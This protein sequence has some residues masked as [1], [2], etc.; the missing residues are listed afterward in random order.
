[1]VTLHAS[2][3]NGVSSTLAVREIKKMLAERFHIMHAT[4]EIEYDACVDE[5][6]RARKLC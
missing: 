2:V 1:M 5:P 4:V 6:N 3:T